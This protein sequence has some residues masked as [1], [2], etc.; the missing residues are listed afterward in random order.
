MFGQTHNVFCVPFH[1]GYVKPNMYA[2]DS[3]IKTIESNYTISPERNKWGKKTN[4]SLHHEHGDW[5]ND[6]F[7]C[8]DKTTL[9]SL[10][11]KL[12]SEFFYQNRIEKKFNI[13]IVNYTAM[14][15]HQGMSAH[16]HKE[17]DFSLVHYVRVPKTP[18]RIFLYNPNTFDHILVDTEIELEPKEDMFVIFPG[19]IMHQIK[20][21][22]ENN[23]DCLRMAIV[24]NIEIDK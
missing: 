19:Y 2:K 24:A 13:D 7:E 23:D 22:K 16:A 8:L 4:M 18:N 14:K 1:L 21:T 17:A 10:Y 11:D 3:I 9:Y 15:S 6:Q 12:V 20:P 5:G